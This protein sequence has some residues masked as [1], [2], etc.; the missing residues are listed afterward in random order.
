MLSVIYPL[1]TCFEHWAAKPIRWSVLM[2]YFHFSIALMPFLMFRRV[3]AASNFISSN[4]SQ[5]A[6]GELVW[7]GTG[8]HTFISLL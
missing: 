3:I 1:P 2:E 5:G 4:A 6:T 8:K 7:K